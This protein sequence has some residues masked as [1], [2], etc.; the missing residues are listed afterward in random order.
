MTT[1]LLNWLILL[2]MIEVKVDKGD[3]EDDDDFED[4]DN[5]KII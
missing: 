2:P 1:I 4:N 3:D 5:N